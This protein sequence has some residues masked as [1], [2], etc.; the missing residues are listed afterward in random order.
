MEN[1]RGYITL[2]LIAI[3]FIAV[4]L[5]IVLGVM[6]Y[7]FNLVS[8]SFNNIDFSLGNTTFNSTYQQNLAPGI[9]AMRLTVPK[10][11]AMGTFYGMIIVMMLIAYLSYNIDPL[12]ML[13]DFP[14][15]I[16]CEVIAFILSS[17]VQ[18]FI[19]SNSQF[20]NIYST[21]PLYESAT[22]ILNLPVYVPI[23]GVLI[24]ITTYI[25]NKQKNKGVLT[26]EF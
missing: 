21:T 5:L 22:F 13:L 3:I 15:L 18:D 12:W 8:T 14:I 16:A 23:I 17:S 7:S 24:M 6:V 1:K 4:M 26:N 2:G 25:L 11:I 9:D 19:N 10:T 20:L